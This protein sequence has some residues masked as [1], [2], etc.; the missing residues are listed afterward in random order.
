[1][2]IIARITVEREKFRVQNWKAYLNCDGL[3]A[4]RLQP[5]QFQR[6]RGHLRG[7]QQ[8]EPLISVCREQ[9]RA[10]S[11]GRSAAIPGV[12][13]RAFKGCDLTLQTLIEILVLGGYP[14]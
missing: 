5:A 2:L 12:V 4:E 7:P 14:T 3:G 6:Y 11:H 10:K 13:D 1:M 9:F 8:Y